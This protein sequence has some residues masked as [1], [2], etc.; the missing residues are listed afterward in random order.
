MEH[1]ISCILT[2]YKLKEALIALVSK[3]RAA[4]FLRPQYPNHSTIMKAITVYLH[5]GDITK[6]MDAAEL[7][8]AHSE[9]GNGGHFGIYCDDQGLASLLLDSTDIGVPRQFR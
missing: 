3:H 1:V 2:Y 6:A 9:V 8:H 7:V 5:T 4:Q